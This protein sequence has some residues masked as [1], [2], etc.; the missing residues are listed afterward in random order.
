MHCLPPMFSTWT[1]FSCLSPFVISCI[2]G[3]SESR[4]PSFS[5]WQSKSSILISKSPLIVALLLPTVCQINPFGTIIETGPTCSLRPSTLD[6]SGEMVFEHEER[7]RKASKS[8]VAAF[9]EK[10]MAGFLLC[11]VDLFLHPYWETN[12]KIG[13]CLA[14]LPES[15]QHPLGA[16]KH[17]VESQVVVI[18]VVVKFLVCLVWFAPVQS[19]WKQGLEIALP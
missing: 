11:I 1:S 15:C 5:P 12:Q 9:N 6:V 3:E 13:L 4:S 16:A 8:K 7:E 19:S 2:I 17:V 18:D 14:P 10:E